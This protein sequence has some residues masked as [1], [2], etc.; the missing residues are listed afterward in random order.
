MEMVN[1]KK[2]DIKLILKFVSLFAVVFTVDLSLSKLH[3]INSQ[4]FENISENSKT[5]EI[6]Y[7]EDVTYKPKL[8][9]GHGS[10]Y[11]TSNGW[12]SPDYPPI[13]IEKVNHDSNDIIIEMSSGMGPNEPENIRN[14]LKSTVLFELR[15]KDGL[16][17]NWDGIEILKEKKNHDNDVHGSFSM[18]ESPSFS[19]NSQNNNVTYNKTDYTSD[20]NNIRLN[21]N[22]LK[23]ARYLAITTYK[24]S[25]NDEV[26]F[27]IQ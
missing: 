14:L 1:I 2:L 24:T 15:D 10:L 19:A 26:V 11:A 6:K 4:K 16:I 22:E 18:I 7:D 23:L 3:Q 27:K 25:D 13:C 12:F 9:N 8:S 17:I 21:G 20:P 5:K